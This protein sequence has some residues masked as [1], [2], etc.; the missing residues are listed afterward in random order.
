[1]S[2]CDVVYFPLALSDGSL[3]FASGCSQVVCSPSDRSF[4][5]KIKGAKEQ[6][7]TSSCIPDINGAVRLGF[8]LTSHL[9]FAVDDK[10]L[11]F[12]P[13]ISGVSPSECCPSEESVGSSIKSYCLD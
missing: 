2:L 3:D 10:M 5:Q 4:T 12:N 1:M 9:D 13:S 6:S 7:P 11:P 8:F